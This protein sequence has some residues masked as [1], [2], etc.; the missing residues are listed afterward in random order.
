MNYTPPPERLGAIRAVLEQITSASKVVLTT[1]LHA[2]GDGIG[3]QLALASWIRSRGGEAWVIN[4]T[5]F[6][7]LFS[8]LVPDPQWVAEASSERAASLCAAADL[9][10]VLDTAVPDRIGSVLGLT[11]HLP[12]VVIDHHVIADD[13]LDGVEFRDPSAAATGELIYDLLVSGGMEPTPTIVQGVYVAL[14]TDTGGFRFSNSSPR[15]HRIVAELI[16]GGAEP[17]RL[18]RQVYG[19]VPLRRLRLLREVLGTLELDPGGRVAW[20][21][22]PRASYEELGADGEDLEGMVDFPRSIRGVEVGMLFRELPDDTTKVSFRS[23]GS[24][25]VNLLARA[26]GGGGHQ[27]A[28]GALIRLSLSAATDAVITAALEAVSVS[29]G[30]SP[31]GGTEE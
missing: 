18:N 1:H 5:P 24:V 3:S 28:S 8:F 16:E 6:P 13:G 25:D 14:L 30:P 19:A 9:L 22:V 27:K 23:T 11:E 26:F 12:R 15:C 17:E 7:R 20:A 21:I 4:P 31:S 29:R 2:D 10:V